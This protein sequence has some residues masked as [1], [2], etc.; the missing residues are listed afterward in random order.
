MRGRNVPSARP[1]WLPRPCTPMPLRF[2]R[3][4]GG[5]FRIGRLLRLGRRCRRLGPLERIGRRRFL[6]RFLRRLRINRALRFTGELL[7][8]RLLLGRLLLV[9]RLLLR[10]TPS[11]GR[12]SHFRGTK[13]FQQAL[14][15]AAGLAGP[16][17]LFHIF[18]GIALHA[19]LGLLNFLAFFTF[20]GFL[21][22]LGLAALRGLFSRPC[23]S[24]LSRSFRPSRDR[25][26]SRPSLSR[27]SGFRCR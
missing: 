20:L 4:G 3:L 17:L 22:L 25:S 5:L 23:P 19:R 2:P 7:F 9:G 14:S 21:I 13:S 1:A 8:R 10:P 27:A 16:R 24:Q 12:E 6:R 26:F 15:P 18:L 11:N